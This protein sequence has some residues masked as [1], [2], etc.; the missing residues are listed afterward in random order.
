[1]LLASRLGIMEGT[2]N[3]MMT[4]LREA[5]YPCVV[6]AMIFSLIFFDDSMNPKLEA[7]K[8]WRGMM[9]L[10]FYAISLIVLMV[11]N[12]VSAYIVVWSAI[13]GA[14][15]RSKHDRSGR[16]DLTPSLQATVSSI[17]LP[18]TKRPAR[19]R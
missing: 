12:G 19:F 7:G 10:P 2:I 14:S 9:A 4:K 3:S 1:M 17:Q 11:I 5:V 16:R 15:V 13:M 6:S 18:M 8:T